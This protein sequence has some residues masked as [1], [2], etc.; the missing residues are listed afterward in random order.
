MMMMYLHLVGCV[1]VLWQIPAQLFDKGV[2]NVLETFF[3]CLLKKMR[4][5]VDVTQIEEQTKN[6]KASAT[7]MKIWRLTYFGPVEEQVLLVEALVNKY[8]PIFT[9][10]PTNLD[11]ADLL[12]E[13]CLQGRHA[14][15][16]R[17][18][19]GTPNCT[20]GVVKVYYLFYSITLFPFCCRATFTSEVPH[21]LSLSGFPAGLSQN[22]S[23][24]LI[25]RLD[26]LLLNLLHSSKRFFLQK[27]KY[28][29]NLMS[30]FFK[31][32]NKLLHP[33]VKFV[34]RRAEH[35]FQLQ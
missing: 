28:F 33:S 34:G 11:K 12:Q 19:L 27:R 20:K 25:V 24:P 31:V 3:R 29:F 13:V 30:F 26:T 6:C 18:V 21:W 10:P 22:G 8:P 32:V 15:R 1:S 5:A 14:F 9:F 2:T 35:G 16:Y 7:A 17:K 4:R 23:G